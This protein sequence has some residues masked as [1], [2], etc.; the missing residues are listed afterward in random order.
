MS[1]RRAVHAEILKL[2]RLLQVEPAR[3]S[4]LEAVRVEDLRAFR[5]Q[6]TE[7]LFAA[8]DGAL[9]R[10]AATSRLLPV[11][12]VANLARTT[13]GP[14]LAARVAGLLEPER[15]DDV[16]QRLPTEFVADI[17][18]ELD[19]RRASAVIA[20]IPPARILEITRVLARRKEYVTMGRFVGHL[21]DEALGAAL[22][23]L[24][25]EDLVQTLVV[26]EE[27]LDL[28]RLIQLGG[29]DRVDRLAALPGSPI[30]RPRRR[31]RAS[32][33]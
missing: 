27:P 25:D 2:A 10:L 16:G 20:R 32:S 12:L 30:A 29:R 8:H 15:A 33:G 14:V 17:A 31:S 18:I 11:A 26:M 19:P 5:D 23:A 22:E 7:A 21:D 4:Y 13:F 6:A 9:R 28:D 1:D 24:S 3:L